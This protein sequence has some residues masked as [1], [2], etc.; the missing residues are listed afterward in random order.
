MC[1]AVQFLSTRQLNF[2]QVWNLMGNIALTTYFP[3]C[4]DGQQIVPGYLHIWKVKDKGK[5]LVK[6]GVWFLI[7]HCKLPTPAPTLVSIVGGQLQPGKVTKH[8]PDKI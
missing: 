3:S 8:C 2:E 1:Y 7:G 5:L 6:F 4:P